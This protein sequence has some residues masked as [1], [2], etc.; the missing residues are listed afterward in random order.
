VFT[1]E[2]LEDFEATGFVR[3]RGAFARD[4]AAA[5]EGRVWRALEGRLGA[6]RDDPGSWPRGGVNGLQGM[7]R[8]PVFDAIGAGALPSALDALF[9]ASAWAPPKDWGQMLVTFPSAGPSAGRHPWHTDF[10][11]RGPPDRV[12]GALVFSYLNDVP[13]GG[14]GTLAVAG[15]HRVIQRFLADRPQ[16]TRC[17]MRD[18]RHALM[19]SD[20]WLERLAEQE[21]PGVID[22]GALPG[23]GCVHGEAVQVVELDGAAGDVVIGHP[24]L[25]HRGAPNCGA[26]PRLMRVSRVLRARGAE[27]PSG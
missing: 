17:P 2:L 3:L 11:F 5:M 1:R 15:S 27:R 14:G 16:L 23:R 6:R 20:P 8:E 4:A 21:N 9:G 19:R 7:K 26:A 24:W 12:F 18:T 22:M 10:E 25:L 13:L